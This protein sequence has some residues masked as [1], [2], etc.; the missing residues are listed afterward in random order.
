MSSLISDFRQRLNSS[1]GA[2]LVG[3]LRGAL[4]AVGMK[5]AD[6]LG[7][8]SV[9]VLEF[10][11]SAQRADVMA[12]TCGIDVSDAVQ[13]AVTFCL[14]NGLNLTVE[15]L[16]RL[17]KPVNIDRAV[18]STTNEFRIIGR[19]SR[20]GFYTAGAISMFSTSLPGFT[21]GG[22]G[23]EGII[24]DQLH[25]EAPDNTVACFALDGNAFLRMRVKNCYFRRVR[26][27]Y[28]SNFF[29]TWTIERCNIRKIKGIFM[30]AAIAGT[31]YV[32]LDGYGF[33]LHFSGNIFEDG[34]PAQSA[35]LKLAGN[36]N[37]GSMTAN[38]FE[39]STGPFLEIGGGGTLDISGNYFEAVT[40]SV[41]RLGAT[42]NIAFTGNRFGTGADPAYWPIDCQTSYTV[43]GHGNF[44]EGNIYKSS[45]MQSTRVL[46]DAGFYTTAAKGLLSVGDVA[47]NGKISDDPSHAD[48]FKRLEAGKLLAGVTDYSIGAAPQLV[49]TLQGDGVSGVAPISGFNVYTTPGFRDSCALKIVISD[50]A[51]GE[52]PDPILTLSNDL[53]ATAGAIKVRKGITMDAGFM[54]LPQYT[55]QTRPPYVK[56]AMFFDTTLN[57]VVIGG[58][59]GWE[60]VQSTP[61]A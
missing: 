51:N 8:Q 50:V 39:G 36:Y 10:M 1:I 57:K 13:R 60:A 33:D 43:T 26:L 40:Q 25:F 21:P 16:C 42:L 23:A 48:Q 11:T 56:Y 22:P 61:I 47:Y 2:A 3:Y 27:A 35:F 52:Y 14:A 41:F 46:T 49:M 17:D 5:M 15:G 18:D 9:S 53:V 20:A 19:N 34:D 38:L 59:N 30:E 6:W 44:S 55:A 28:T 58:A 45:A 37:G 4:G 32:G 12:G 54:Y 7:W 24:F 29:Q 31:S